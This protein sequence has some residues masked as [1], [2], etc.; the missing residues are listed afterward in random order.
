MYEPPADLPDAM[1]HYLQM[2]NEPDIERV[3]GHLDLAV[4]PDCVWVDPLHNHVGRD[5][6]EANVTEF[7]T[8]YPG[9]ELRLGSNVD[10]HNNRYRYEWVIV[11][12]GELLVRGFDVMAM[13]DDG[14]IER[15][16]GFFGI[17]E[18]TGPD[19]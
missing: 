14:L 13:N 3:R 17:L 18:R 5:A 8:S 11:V 2:W 10:S 19:M 15:V 6:L 9:A 12:D 16:D 7:R 1:R 4:S